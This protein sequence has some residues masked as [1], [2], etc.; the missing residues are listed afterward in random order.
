V[1]GSNWEV[2]YSCPQCGAPVILGEADRLLA[3]GFCRTRLYLASRTAF[4]YRFGGPSGTSSEIL[5]VPYWRLRGSAFSV[6]LP[7]VLSRF[8]DTSVL[9]VD[10]PG[11]P[12]SLG[13]RPQTMRLKILSP[14]ETGRILGPSVSLKEA[15]PALGGSG[16]AIHR[17]FIG[18]TT[19]LVYAPFCMQGG[20]L[21]DA[22]LRRTVPGWTSGMSEDLLSRPE[23][24]N[25]RVSFVPA[26]CPRCGWDLEGEKDAVVL[27]CR[28]CDSAWSCPEEKLQ[29]VTFAVFEKEKADA[30]LPFWRMRMKIEEAEL[31]SYADLVRE[32]NLPKAPSAVLEEKPLHFWSPAF[33]ISPALFLRWNRGMTVF[34]PEAEGKETFPGTMLHPANLPLSEAAESIVLTIASLVTDKRRWHSLLPRLNPRLEE[35]VLVYHPFVA[36][37]AELVHAAMGLTVDRRALAFGTHL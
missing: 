25:W 21:R 35:A 32:A 19:S 6:D 1:N 16:A 11:I 23:D 15:M 14:D 18:E 34:Q 13:L 24:R 3:C 37:R 2:E 10:L 26:L 28:H 27:L 12:Q 7:G 4:R 8:I 9:A 33:K 30:Y 31:N 20:D 17:A 29:P 5:Y 22:V 36:E